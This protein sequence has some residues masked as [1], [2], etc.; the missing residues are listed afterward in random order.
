M[1]EPL[2]CSNCRRPHQHG[3]LAT[4]SSRN[5]RCRCD[6]CRKASAKNRA[7]SRRAE[8]TGIGHRSV[9]AQETQERLRILR[10]RGMTIRR[11]A[12]ETGLSSNTI[13]AII[14]FDDAASR[15]IHTD[16]AETILAITPP[17]KIDEVSDT[18]RGPAKGTRV[19]LQALQAIGWS[20]RAVATEAGLGRSHLTV[21]LNGGTEGD[22]INARTMRLVA[23]VYER[24]WNT[25]PPTKTP[26]QRNSVSRSLRRAAQNGWKP[27]MAHD[28]DRIDADLRRVTLCKREPIRTRARQE[29]GKK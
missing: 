5:H 3:E 20:I 9:S 22:L 10:S 23:E 6:D 16:N 27:P 29:A 19:R 8:I 13:S 15:M 28:D 26:T 7:L 2:D 1:S 17:R 11:I 25:R 4:Y 14:N 21:V 24:L 12:A 18:M